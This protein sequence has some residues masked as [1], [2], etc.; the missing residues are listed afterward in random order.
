M[1][2]HNHRSHKEISW[3]RAPAPPSV[4]SVCAE[5]FAG[6]F[7]PSQRRWCPVQDLGTQQ[8]GADACGCW[9]PT[10]PEQLQGKEGSVRPGMCQPRSRA[11]AILP[12]EG[13]EGPGRCSP[14]SSIHVWRQRFSSPNQDSLLSQHVA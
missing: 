3:K 8:L 6:R 1:A 14:A 11:G 4:S 12:R 9:D 13:W 5:E 7:A 2:L 10:A